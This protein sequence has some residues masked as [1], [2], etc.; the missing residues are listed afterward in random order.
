MEQVKGLEV[1]NVNM[2]WAKDQS[3]W[4]NNPLDFRPST[5]NNISLINFRSGLFDK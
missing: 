5:V 1:R 2:L 4:W 3:Q